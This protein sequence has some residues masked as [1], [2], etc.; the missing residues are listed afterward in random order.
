MRIAGSSIAASK[1]EKSTV[2]ATMAATA[3]PPS[4]RIHNSNIV[5]SHAD[6]QDL[7]DA[8]VN[9]GTKRVPQP[10]EII[11]AFGPRALNTD[12]LKYLVRGT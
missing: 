12:Q 4:A 1:T 11:D 2:T 7:I 3:P 8:S 9:I 10:Q 5:K 6:A